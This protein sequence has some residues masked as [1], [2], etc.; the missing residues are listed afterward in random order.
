MKYTPKRGSAGLSTAS[1]ALLG[2]G[3]GLAVGCGSRGAGEAVVPGLVQAAPSL[4]TDNAVYRTSRLE[5]PRFSH[6]A[7]TLEDGKVIVAGGTDERHLT[8]LATGEVFDQTTFVD[9]P[10]QSVTGDFFDTDINGDPIVMQEGS[11]IF[12]TATLL[13]DGTVLIAGGT[14][15]I[16]GG[17]AIERAEIFDPQSRVFAPDF[18]QIDD[19]MINPRFRHTATTL[20]TGKIMFS[21]GQTS[22]DVTIIDPNWP[23]GHPLFMVNIKTFPSTETIELFNPAALAFEP[24]LDS[25]GEDVELGTSRGRASHGAVNIAGVDGLLNTGDDF[26]IY[27]GGYRT[28]SPVFAPQ[29]KFVRRNIDI[30]PITTVEFLDRIAGEV[31]SANGIQSALRSETPQIFNLGRYNRFT[32]DGVDGVN[33]IVMVCNGMDGFDQATTTHQSE[34]ITVSFTGLGPSSGIDFFMN[35]PISALQGIEPAVVANFMCA[36]PLGV[37][38]S[39]APAIQ[40][41]YIR[42]ATFTNAAGDDDGSASFFGSWVVTCGGV[43]LF[44]RM[45][46]QYVHQTSC[47]LNDVR[48]FEYFDPFYDALNANDPNDLDNGRDIDNHPAPNPP[49]GVVGTWLLADNMVGLED[50]A[51]FADSNATAVLPSD[52]VYHSLSLV[53]GEDGIL[54][55]QDDR[56]VVIGGGDDFA[57]F[58]GEPVANSGLIFL[59]DG[60]NGP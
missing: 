10:V 31:R 9:P 20:P 25:L 21:G 48:A 16:L 30:S 7:T 38:R 45:A 27:V 55:T 17:E 33:N 5:T 29:E 60:A 13:P 2:L 49:T 35:T 12:H 52:T 50:F 24:L 39:A 26:T 18:L 34:I 14:R 36:G 15:D 37:G 51:G 22:V 58:G 43:T 57:L 19:P 32:P 11:R 8:S 59:P 6:T 28:F 53:P 42:S 54:N 56:L 47:T 4:P 23:P 1:L 41:P 46:Q 44:P 3:L 40:V